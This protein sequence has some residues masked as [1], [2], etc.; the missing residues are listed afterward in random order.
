MNQEEI[1]FQIRS[2]DILA[3]SLKNSG[4]IIPENTPFRFETKIEHRINSA[5]K[6]IMVISSF[7][8]F[9]EETKND[10]GNA[11]ISCV[12]H[13]ENIQQFMDESGKFVLPSPLVTMFNSISISTCRGVLFTLFRGTPL[14]SVILPIIN[15]QDF[16]NTNI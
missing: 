10:M 13:I 4:T 15:P 11:E 7:N 5:E 1:K 3:F 16:S 6:T 9:C 14:H 8:I 12:Y 2:I